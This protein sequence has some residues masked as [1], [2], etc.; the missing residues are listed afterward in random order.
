MC[1][2]DWSSFE[3]IKWSI[4]TVTKIPIALA[5]R[6]IKLSNLTK[7]AKFAVKATVEIIKN[8]GL[9]FGI[10]QRLS[11]SLR[12]HLILYKVFQQNWCE[13]QSFRCHREGETSSDINQR[14]RAIWSRKQLYRTNSGIS[15]LLLLLLL[16]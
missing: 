3:K 10:M 16:S 11:K 12:F 4:T 7:P 14:N 15:L 2:H 6:E 5:N 1:L 8:H 9:I 13:T